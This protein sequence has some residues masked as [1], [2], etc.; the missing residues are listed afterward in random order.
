ML[1][2]RTILPLPSNHCFAIYQK[3]DFNGSKSHLNSFTFHGFFLLT[4][5]HIFCCDSYRESV[6][7]YRD[8]TQILWLLASAH[9]GDKWW[10]VTNHW[11]CTLHLYTFT[12]W[13]QMTRTHP[14]Q[15]LDTL[16]SL[17]IHYNMWQFVA[18][19]YIFAVRKAAKHQNKNLSSKSALLIPTVSTSAF[20]ST[21]LFLFSCHHIPTNSVAPLSA[22]KPTHN[23]KFLQSLWRKAYARN[24][25]FF[26][27]YGGQLTFSTQLLT[28]NY[29]LYS[30]TDAAPQF[31]KKLTP[32]TKSW[33]PN[34]YIYQGSVSNFLIEIPPPLLSVGM[35][36]LLKFY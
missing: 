1:F 7:F 18:F 35:G 9:S 2:W 10:L 31:L 12:T 20:H 24:V 8:T 27:L 33:F 36:F 22:Y 29:L 13:K 23:P 6:K 3:S 17:I 32:F 4:Q 16:I 34:W 25:S 5:D 11:L 28:L 21:N 19:P 26:T 15:S 14:N 30:T